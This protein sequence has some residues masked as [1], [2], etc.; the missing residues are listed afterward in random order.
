MPLSGGEIE[1]VGGQS[2]L[3]TLFDYVGTA[4]HVE[5]HGKIVRD[6]AILRNLINVSTEIAAKCY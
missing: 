2:Y 1:A 4:A 5:H 6:K 3:S